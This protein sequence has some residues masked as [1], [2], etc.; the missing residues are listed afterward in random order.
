MCKPINGI[1]Q[2]NKVRTKITWSFKEMQK[3]PLIK[4]GT[5]SW[6]KSTEETRNKRNVPQYHKSSTGKPVAKKLLE[7]I[8][9]FGKIA[10]YK[11]NMQK[12]VA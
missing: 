12:S 2:I 8:S 6:K 11:I 5:I 4:F 10:E 3:K 7:I 9:F 1:E